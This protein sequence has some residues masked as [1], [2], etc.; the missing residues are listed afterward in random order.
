MGIDIASNS[1]GWMDSCIAY[2]K[3]LL[4]KA[5]YIDSSTCRVL[6]PPLPAPPPKPHLRDKTRTHQPQ[7]PDGKPRPTSPLPAAPLVAVAVV[8][9]ADAV[10]PDS[11][12]PSPFPVAVPDAAPGDEIT[13]PHPESASAAFTTLVTVAISVTTAL[14]EPVVV[15]VV[16]VQVCAIPLVP[17]HAEH[18]AEGSGVPI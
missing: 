8:P 7:C 9:V 11:A 6:H 4:S 18:Q 13:D 17:L 16:V 3:P 10:A 15:V 14:F 5:R 12:T 1:L 2:K